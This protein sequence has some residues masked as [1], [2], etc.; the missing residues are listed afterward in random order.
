MK[1]SLYLNKKEAKKYE[2]LKEILNMHNRPSYI[3]SLGLDLL[4]EQLKEEEKKEVKENE[5]NWFWIIQFWHFK[6]NF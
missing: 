6:S 5:N 3:F 1:I 2:E 4:Y